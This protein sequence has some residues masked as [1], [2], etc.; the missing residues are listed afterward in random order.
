MKHHGL[1]IKVFNFKHLIN[2]HG[3]DSG[4]GG[5]NR[6]SFRSPPALFIQS[7]IVCLPLA[8]RASSSLFA[9]QTSGSIPATT[10]QQISR[11]KSDP[12]S[13]KAERKRRSICRDM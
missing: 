2:V 1:F 4:G 9:R 7:R 6:F 11:G 3:T 10:P 8:I 5:G 12:I 13:R